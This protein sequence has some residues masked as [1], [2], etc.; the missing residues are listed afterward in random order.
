[1]QFS[2]AISTEDKL[3]LIHMNFQNNERKVNNSFTQYQFLENIRLSMKNA[4]LILIN[5]V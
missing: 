3:Y 5:L 4:I 1:M 2:I